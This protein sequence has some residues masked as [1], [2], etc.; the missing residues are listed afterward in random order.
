MEFVLDEKQQQEMKNYVFNLIKTSISNATDNVRP[1]LNRKDAAKFFGVSENTISNWAKQGCPVCVVN[2]MKLYGK[3]SITQ[4]LKEHETPT[5]SQS[6]HT[7]KPV[8]MA[9]VTDLK[10]KLEK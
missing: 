9:V 3:K 10:T 1:Y 2:G 6:Q 5:E 8:T 4:W 7:K